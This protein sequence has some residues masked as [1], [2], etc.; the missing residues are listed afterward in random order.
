MIFAT[1]S[2]EVKVAQSC[3][4]LCDPIGL[5]SP[6]NSPGQNTGVGSP[7]LLQG[8]LPTPGSNPGLPHCRQILYQLSHQGSPFILVL[9][10][11]ILNNKCTLLFLGLPTLAVTR[12]FLLWSLPTE[13]EQPHTTHPGHLGPWSTAGE[14][15]WHWAQRPQAGGDPETDMKPACQRQNVPREGLWRE[16][17]WDTSSSSGLICSWKEVMRNTS[18]FLRFLLLVGCVLK[19]L[20]PFLP[21][22]HTLCTSS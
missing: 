11:I 8:T 15:K 6:W 17:N 13:A 9:V 5:Y 14:S 10:S 21:G 12:S 3:R 2:S 19:A 22:S 7:S 16:L 20:H 1:S 4:T 18:V